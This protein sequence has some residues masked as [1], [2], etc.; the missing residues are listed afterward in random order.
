MNQPGDAS[1]WVRCVRDEPYGE[2]SE[3]LQ[4][5]IHTYI[6]MLLTWY[7][8]ISLFYDLH[9]GMAGTTGDTINL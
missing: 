1:C 5:H 2:L 8:L 9:P 4:L 3:G 7:L 6:G